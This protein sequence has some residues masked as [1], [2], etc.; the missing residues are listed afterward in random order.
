MMMHFLVLVDS[1]GH[2]QFERAAPVS[3]GCYCTSELQPARN[4]TGMLE[5]PT[6]LYKICGKGLDRTQ[7][8]CLMGEACG[9]FLSVLQRP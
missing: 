5:L 9:G 1:G 6:C 4:Y 3:R 7:N 8:I 2:H